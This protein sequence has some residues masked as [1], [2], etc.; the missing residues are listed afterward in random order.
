[1]RLASSREMKELDRIAIEERKIPSIDLMERAADHIV[2]AVRTRMRG[3]DRAAALFCGTGNNG[4]DGLAAARKLYDAGILARAFLVGDPQKLT[5]DAREECRRLEAAGFSLEY[6]DESSEEQRQWTMDCEVIVDALFGVGLSRDIEEGSIYASAVRLMNESPAQV[7]AADIAS[8]L[9]ADSGRV[10]G[11]AVRAEETVTFSLPKIGQFLGEG[12]AYSGKVRVQDIGL[13]RD[14]IEGGLP[15]RLF[16]V[17]EKAAAPLLPERKPDGHKGNFGKVLV[18]GGSVGYTGAPYLCASAAVHGGCG[19]VY[20]G[21]PRSIWAVEAG[22]CVSSMPFPLED[23]DGKLSER[24]LPKILERLESC[25]VLALGPGL[26]RSEGV[27]KLVTALLLQT[28]KPVVLDADGINA[29]EGHIDSLDGRRDRVTILTPHEGEFARVGGDLTSGDRLLAAR[30]FA[31]AHGCTL[32][33]KGHRTITVSPEGEAFL[34]TTGSSGLAKGGSGDVLTGLIASLLAQG[35]SAEAA[36]ALGVW[37]HG[38][39]GDEAE[40]LFTP[41]AVTPEKVISAL[42]RSFSALMRRKKKEE[43]LCAKFFAYQ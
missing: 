29:L 19:L 27:T 4:G 30:T 12:P 37:L 1:M 23:A 13:P 11:C 33:L 25:D 2:N 15:S 28:E 36:S 20:L 14:L 32:V 18:V 42:P 9:A 3:E 35:L 10:L 17:D 38:R 21:V 43:A 7:V 39:A 22:K 16:M 40:E 31:K 41:Y 6:Y 26:G 24:A 8:G 34:N 5:K